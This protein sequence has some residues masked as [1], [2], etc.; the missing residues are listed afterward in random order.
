MMITSG[1]SVI[2]EKKIK[3]NKAKQNKNHCSKE[4][5][6]FGCRVKI[7]RALLMQF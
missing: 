7:L 4:T 3:E 5:V 1:Y 2:K 6:I